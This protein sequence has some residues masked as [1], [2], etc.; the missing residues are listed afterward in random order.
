[1]TQFFN[2]LSAKFKE[3]SPLREGIYLNQQLVDLG[4]AKRV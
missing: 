4:L 1:M 2:T 3:F